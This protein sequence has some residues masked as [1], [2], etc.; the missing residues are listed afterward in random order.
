[1]T[2]ADWVPGTP[3]LSEWKSRLSKRS[4]PTSELYTGQLFGYRENY[5]S[6]KIE[7][8]EEWVFMIKEEGHAV[9]QRN[10]LV[11]QRWN[12]LSFSRSPKSLRNPDGMLKRY[13]FAA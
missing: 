12:G 1:M 10:I 11:A 2:L 3:K 6:K 5:P 7:T 4:V 8:L 9:P 13:L